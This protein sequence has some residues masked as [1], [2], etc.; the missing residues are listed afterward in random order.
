M[1]DSETIF[2]ASLDV[3]TEDIEQK[4]CSK[5]SLFFS[6]HTYQEHLQA[7]GDCSCRV[8]TLG[9]R[10]SDWWQA[11]AK[12][13]LEIYKRLIEISR[14]MLSNARGSQLNLNQ[15]QVL[16]GH[17][18]MLLAG[19]VARTLA[20]QDLVD[21]KISLSR[22]SK[23]YKFATARSSHES[24]KIITSAEFS[25]FVETSLI[26]IKSSFSYVAEVLLIKPQ[27]FVQKVGFGE[28][29]Y[30]LFSRAIAPLTRI[31]KHLIVGTYLGRLREAT[32]ALLFLQLPILAE[33][34]FRDIEGP[35]LKILP[36]LCPSDVDP[37]DSFLEDC[38]RVL[39]P[40]SLLQGEAKE[41]IRLRKLGWPRHPKSVF[42]SNNFDSDDDFKNLV[43]RNWNNILYVVGQHGN[44]YGVSQ[45]SLLYPETW[46][47]DVFA[48]WGWVN[49]E[50]NL[51]VGILKPLVKV[52][53]QKSRKGFLLILR[54]ANWLQLEADTYLTNEVY[55]NDIARFI[56][57]LTSSGCRVRVRSHPATPDWVKP[58]IIETCKS[59]QLLSFSPSGVKLSRELRLWF[60]VFGYDSTGMLELASVGEAFCAFVPEGL[61]GVRLPFREIYSA[62]E[63]V[64]LISTDPE[65]AMEAL[66]KIR[67]DGYLISNEQ[68]AALHFFANQLAVRNKHL[69][70]FLK[71]ILDT[72]SRTKMNIADKSTVRWPRLD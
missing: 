11:T 13:R 34:R 21:G 63:D 8:L 61:N 54:D 23:K 71:N 43:S 6:W 40:Q 69:L 44:N 33:V 15:V 24:Y 58:L 30:V 12:N 17:I 50:N 72:F 22:E 7:V 52:A 51:P 68:M 36:K 29:M 47:S 64:R 46:L 18:C 27:L 56:Q 32:L 39:I 66:L 70:T 2:F 35:D 37:M 53:S 1:A 59:S 42:T 62:I 10:N 16:V 14:P 4:K 41:V 20:Q 60:P 3:E 49:Q 19:R 5:N 26:S 48:T 67:Q 38:L 65:I 25:S 31:S 28:K 55:F 9:T 57:R 45:N